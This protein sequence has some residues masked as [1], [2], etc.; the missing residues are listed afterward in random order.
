MKSMK[1]VL[2]VLAMVAFAFVLSGCPGKNMTAND[3]MRDDGMKQEASMS[4]DGM[5]KDKM[6]AED[7]MEKDKM[8]Q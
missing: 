7:G 2:P 8:D 5:E 6:M 3:G 4:D 1:L